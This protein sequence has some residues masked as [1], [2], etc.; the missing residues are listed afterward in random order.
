MKATVRLIHL[1]GTPFGVND[2]L[3]P[4]TTGPLKKSL[5]P[6]FQGSSQVSRKPTSQLPV[7]PL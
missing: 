6:I 1:E 7:V 2:V 3:N 4:Q 5:P